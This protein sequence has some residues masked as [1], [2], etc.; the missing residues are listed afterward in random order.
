[1]EVDDKDVLEM[2]YIQN[3]K[4]SIGH[5]KLQFNLERIKQG[6]GQYAPFPVT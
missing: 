1:M 4:S 6:N 3:N 2:S 5:D